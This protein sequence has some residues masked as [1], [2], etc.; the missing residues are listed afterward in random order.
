MFTR[1]VTDRICQHINIQEGFKE[2]A[3]SLGQ[4]LWV[5]DKVFDDLDEIMQPMAAHTRDLLGFKYY[6]D[7]QGP[8]EKAEEIRGKEE[9]FKNTLCVECFQGKYCNYSIV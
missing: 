7:T 9:S 1:R 6:Q 3:C 8:N 2:N 5:G 4:S